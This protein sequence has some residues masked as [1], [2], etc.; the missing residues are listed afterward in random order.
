MNSNSSI[1]ALGARDF[2]SSDAPSFSTSSGAASEGFASANIEG[3]ASETACVVPASIDPF[4]ILPSALGASA[5]AGVDAFTDSMTASNTL[6]ILHFFGVAAVIPVG[7]LDS[8]ANFFSRDRLKAFDYSVIFFSFGSSAGLNL[9]L[10]GTERLGSDIEADPSISF[11]TSAVSMRLG[12][13]IK[14]FFDFGALEV[15]E[16][17]VFLFFPCFREG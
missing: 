5:E 8:F 2:D 11:G 6:A 16:A 7:I 13:R 3:P 4:K 15:A 12:Q 17:A 9:A 14:T 1:D 10:T